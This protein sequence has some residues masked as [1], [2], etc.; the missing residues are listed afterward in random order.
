M[1]MDD[2]CDSFLLKEEGSADVLTW[3]FESVWKP[4]QSSVTEKQ[5]LFLKLILHVST[6]E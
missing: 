2:L 4:A 3:T 6:P 5:I 1:T